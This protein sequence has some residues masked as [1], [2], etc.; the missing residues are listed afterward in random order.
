MITNPYIDVPADMWSNNAISTISNA[1]ILTGDSDGRF[2]PADSIS[3]GEFAAIAAR[4]SSKV[5]SGE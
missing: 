4:F 2:R 3:H 1:K 5:Y